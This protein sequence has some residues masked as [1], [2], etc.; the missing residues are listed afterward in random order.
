[1]AQTQKTAAPATAQYTV[2]RAIFMDGERIEVGDTVEM[3]PLQYAEAANA[4][5]VGPLQDGS[6]AA[7]AAAKP[8]AKKEE[9]AK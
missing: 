1:M 2:L 6:A 9:P 4:G 7:E 8:K 3:T 5:K